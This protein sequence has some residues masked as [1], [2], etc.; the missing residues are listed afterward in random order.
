MKN[1]FKT[2]L[3]VMPLIFGHMR[4][5]AKTYQANDFSIT[6]PDAF[7]RVESDE[8]LLYFVESKSGQAISVV[9]GNSGSFGSHDPLYKYGSLSKQ[10]TRKS[11]FLRLNKKYVKQYYKAENV[12]LMQYSFRTYRNQ[13]SVLFKYNSE[14]DL[15]EINYVVK[16]IKINDSWLGKLVSTLRNGPLIWLLFFIAATFIAAILHKEGEDRSSTWVSATLVTL[17]S[18]PFLLLFLWGAWDMLLSFIVITLLIT[19]IAARTGYFLVP[20][21]D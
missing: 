14:Q 21:S 19:Y 16:S 12:S 8:L 6:I 3:F 2:L 10:K 18:I 15:K 13:Y 4:I 9:Y 5:D 1:V 20:Q 11:F 7:A 17:F